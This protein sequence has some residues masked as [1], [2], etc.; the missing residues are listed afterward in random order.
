MN[1]ADTKKQNHREYAVMAILMLLVLCYLAGRGA[2]MAVARATDGKVSTSG[3]TTKNWGLG[4]REEGQ[5][6]EGNESKECL[7]EK[8]AVYLGDE[9][10]KIIYLTFDAGY[11]NGNM[12]K[13]LEALQ[14]HH[15]TATFFVVGNFIEKN[16]DLVKKMSDM[17]QHLANHSYSHPDMSGMDRESFEAELRKLEDCY[18][19]ITGEEMVKLYRPPMGKYSDRSLMYAREMGYRTVF[20]SLAYVDW[21]QDQQPSKEEAFEKLLKRIHP[22]A[23]VLLHSTSSTNAQILDELLTKWEEMGYEFGDV[24][25]IS[26]GAAASDGS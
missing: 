2:A 25:M 5:P 26:D 6:P 12:E 20:W 11:E 17:G 10:K 4:F 1:D 13:I 7:K 22:G 18:R 21:N 9:N 14:K 8:N 23:I 15:V 24:A 19:E 16:Q 3:T